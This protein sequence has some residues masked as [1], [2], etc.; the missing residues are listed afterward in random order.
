MDFLSVTF[1]EEYLYSFV[2]FNDYFLVVCEVKIMNHIFIGTNKA[3]KIYF[4][5][6]E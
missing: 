5:L 2:S 4:S 6:L 1:L 3:F